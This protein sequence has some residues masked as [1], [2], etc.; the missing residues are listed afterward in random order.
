MFR[1]CPAATQALPCLRLAQAK[2]AE[3]KAPDLHSDHLD[4]L[5]ATPDSEVAEHQLS[6][7]WVESVTVVAPKEM[8]APLG[9]IRADLVGDHAVW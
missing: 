8:P 7:C 4:D 6:H 3:R 9:G 5:R 2:A 1:H